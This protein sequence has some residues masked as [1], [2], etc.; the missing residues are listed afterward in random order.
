MDK[1]AEVQKL[2]HSVVAKIIIGILVIAGA[3]FLVE[4]RGKILVDKTALNSDTKNVII[5]LTDAT[6]TVVFYIILF[7]K[8]ENRQIA[9]LSAAT[10]IRNAI[11]GFLIGL[12]LQSLFVLIIALTANYS[13][14]KVN[15][16][17]SLVPAFTTSVTAGFVAMIILIGVV[18]RLIEQ[19]AGTAI[20]LLIFLV[21]FP[22][23]HLNAKG[24]SFLF[25][26]AVAVQNGLMLPAS[27]IARRSLWFPIFIHFG[28]DFAEPGIFGGINPSNS[29]TSGLFS[30]KI[31]GSTILT[32]GQ[33][34]PQSSIQAV[35]I[36]FLT[37]MLF[38]WLAKRRGN[39]L[40]TDSSIYTNRTIDKNRSSL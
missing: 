27:Y 25:V 9:E 1:R 33:T 4:G 36:C 15:P 11:P 5:A 30:G 29:I 24:S 39:F 17:S 19:R 8:I 22:I 10:F 14:V 35:I 6:V 32:G 13:I 37:G 21:L 34:G 12:M 28:W 7:K 18:F 40:K 38:L 16:V 23:L 20:A 31:S 26:L 3:V 2:R